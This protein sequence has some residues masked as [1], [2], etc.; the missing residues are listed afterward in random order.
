MRAITNCLT[1]VSEAVSFARFE[2]RFD[3]RSLIIEMPTTDR[4][5]LWNRKVNLL[6]LSIRCITIIVCATASL[7]KQALAA[8]LDSCLLFAFSCQAM[9]VHAAGSCNLPAN[10]H[11]QSLSFMLFSRLPCLALLVV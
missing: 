10:F 11:H 4:E 5:P 3:L 8:Q 1:I 6:N 9:V 2:Y 7:K